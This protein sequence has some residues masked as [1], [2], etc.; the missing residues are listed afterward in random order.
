M[1]P[2]PDSHASQGA[3]PKS[4]VALIQP[5]EQP[6]EPSQAPTHY[7]IIPVPREEPPEEKKM[8]GTYDSSFMIQYDELEMEKEIGRGAYGVVY[9]GRW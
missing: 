3:R 5:P 6:A 8:T 1:Q 7:N 9:K 4:E 2:V